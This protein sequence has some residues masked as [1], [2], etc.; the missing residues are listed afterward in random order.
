MNYQTYEELMAKKLSMIDS[1]IDKRQGS[2]IYDA[3]A[4][5]S[6]EVSK[7]Y[8]DLMMLNDRSYGD[9]ATGIDLTRRALE[10]GVIRKSAVKSILKAEF[11]DGEGNHFDVSVGDRFSYNEIYYT[12]IS[13]VSKGVFLIECEQS[14]KLGNYYSGEIMPVGFIDG[15]AGAFIKDIHID[16]QDEEDDETLRKRYLESFNSEAFGGN[17]A[18]Y[19]NKV[20]SIGVVGG[21][22]VYPAYYGGGTVRIVFTDREHNVPKS[23]E[24]LAVQ[25]ELDP[26]KDGMGNGIAPIGHRVTVEGATAENIIVSAKITYKSG[27]EFSDIEEELLKSIEEYFDGLRAIWDE[28]DDLIVRISYIESRILQ[29]DGVIDVTDT[30]INGLKQ[31]IVVYDYKV[32]VF[33]SFEEVV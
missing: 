1:N 21:V 26:N 23:A 28:G 13:K 5:N 22:K 25:N 33:S 4:P 14:G 3:L 18:D 10:R 24:V 9:T 32:P 6:A 17:I 8:A 2:I 20:K 11:Y 31:N 29:I 12:V 16:G 27:I 30:T 19:K 15:L 7:M